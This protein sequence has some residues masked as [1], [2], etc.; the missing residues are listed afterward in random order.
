[1][2]RTALAGGAIVAAFVLVA[3]IG[4][5]LAPYSPTEQ[6]LGRNYQGP[7]ARHLF[8][9]DDLGRDTLSR[10]IYGARISLGVAVASVGLGLLAGAF[11]G[12]LAGYRGGWIDGLIM[13]AM[14]VLLALPGI[15][16]AV[17]VVA[18][19]GRGLENTVAAVA[20]YATPTFALL[21]RAAALGV[22][23]LDYVA[24]SRA[25]GASDLR[26]MLRHVLPNV[27]SPIIVQAAVMLGTAILIASG[28][29][30]LG[31]GVQPPTPEWGAMLSKGRELIRTTPVTATAPG[32]AITLVVT[33][34]SLLGDALRDAMDPARGSRT[35]PA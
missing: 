7:S 24:A 20:V 21:T 13:R 4:P 23:H 14:D 5:A 9:T 28:L 35:P 15:L 12:L 11:L 18:V 31:L 26:I 30:F 25:S 8:G 22:V 29:S 17:A 32:L 27:L 2:S 19:L 1:M 6:D 10:L 16:L 33:G 34:F 3:T